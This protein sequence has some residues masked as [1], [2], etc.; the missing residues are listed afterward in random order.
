MSSVARTTQSDFPLQK[1]KI[2]LKSVPIRALYGKKK[3][4]V[5]KIEKTLKITLN[6]TFKKTVYTRRI[7]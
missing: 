1:S 2:F 5:V 3:A 4:P 6:Y 7:S